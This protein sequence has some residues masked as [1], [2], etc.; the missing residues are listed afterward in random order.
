MYQEYE[1][2]KILN[3][4]KNGTF[5]KSININFLSIHKKVDTEFIIEL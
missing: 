3:Q 1:L 5:R 4:K 2:L